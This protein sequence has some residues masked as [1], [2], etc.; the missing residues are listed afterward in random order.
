MTRTDAINKRLRD[1]RRKN[2]Q[3]IFC[4]GTFA[5]VEIDRGQWN[6]VPS[7]THSM[8]G[9]E[10]QAVLLLVMVYFVITGNRGFA[11]ADSTRIQAA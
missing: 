2:Q 3:Q 7:A 11:V 6:F 4:K 1:V 5:T 10:F 8:G 9:F